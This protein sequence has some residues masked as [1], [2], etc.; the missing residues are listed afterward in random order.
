ME[1]LKEL[2]EKVSEMNK[3]LSKFSVIDD[4]IDNRPAAYFI[5]GIISTMLLANVN[6]LNF[7]SEVN[8]EKK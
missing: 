4:G 5:Q 7:I 2:K 8:K 1:K 3:F 6:L